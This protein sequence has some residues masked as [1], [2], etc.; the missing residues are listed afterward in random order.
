MTIGSKL[1]DV[2]WN[3]PRLQELLRKTE[4]LRIDARATF[5]PR[6]ARLR[7]SWREGAA[8][9]DVWRVHQTGDFHVIR[10]DRRLDM[11]VGDAVSLDTLRPTAPTAGIVFT[12][13]DAMRAGER[14]E[15]QRTPVVLLWLRA[16]RGGMR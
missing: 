6:P 2:D 3:D 12:Q 11:R 5:K 15:D 16:V 1:I 14:N 8:W 9:F 4:G 10:L 7:L 13:I